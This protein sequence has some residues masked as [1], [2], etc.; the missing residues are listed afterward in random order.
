MFANDVKIVCQV[1]TT[2]YQ[3]LLQFNL[4]KI[5]LW[6]KRNHLPLNYDKC[7]IIT[8]SQNKSP[9]FYKYFFDNYGL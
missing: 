3:Y 4:N 8:F 7:K 6:S 9:F 2:G 5:L 1:K